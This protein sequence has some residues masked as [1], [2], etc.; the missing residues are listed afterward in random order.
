MCARPA[1][2]TAAALL[3]SLA[4]ASALACPRH[5]HH[6]SAHD[7]ARWWTFD[8]LVIPALSLSVAL[9]ALGVRR[10]WRAA[11]VGHGLRRWQVGCYAAGVLSA[12]AALLSP[13]DRLSDIFFS[14]H[15]TQ[16]EVLMLVSAP[17]FV[18]GRPLLPY[19]QALPPRPREAV[20]RALR[21]PAVREAWGTVTGPLFVLLLHA[22]VIWACHIPA[23][24]EAA[25]ASEAVHA[26][27][28]ALFFGTAALFWWA[29]VH[30]RYGRAG[31]GVGVL[32]VFATATHSGLL[33]ALMTVAGG[34]WYPTH[35][36]RSLDWGVDALGDQQL[37]GL[38]MWIPAGILLTTAG[39]A[40]L[41]AWLGESERRARR[42]A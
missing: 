17:L 28:H 42:A 21:R 1:A 4:P 33:G 15:M 9:Y 2:A 19:L 8:P 12:A 11:G 35:A 3:A 31:Y 24:F 41:A 38:I 7:V 34:L 36:R 26:V 10:M 18:L 29:L 40:L 27:Q 16:H 20:V 5:L 13:L 6:L 25:L 22:L 23:L 30:G 14:A 37:A 39:L 32:Y